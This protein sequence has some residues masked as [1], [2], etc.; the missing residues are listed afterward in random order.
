MTAQRVDRLGRL[1]WAPEGVRLSNVGPPTAVSGAS[2]ASDN[3][4]GAFA[5]WVVT[6]HSPVFSTKLRFQR[7][8][9]D[10]TL[11]TPYGTDISGTDGVAFGDSPGLVPDGAGGIFLAWLVASTPTTGELY[12]Q[13]IDAS[14]KLLWSAPSRVSQSDLSKTRPSY[15]S[16]GAGGIVI[17]WKEPGQTLT[18]ILA[19]RI[20]RDG[21]PLWGSNGLVLAASTIQGTLAVGDDG[22]GGFVVAWPG[23]Q[24][25][26]AQRIDAAGDPSWIDGGITVANATTESAVGVVPDQIG[27]V[28]IGMTRRDLSSVDHFVQHVDAGGAML[29]N[30]VGVRV[31]ESIGPH[32]PLN[33]FGLQMIADGD[34]GTIVS[35]SEV[36][37]RSYDDETD[38]RAQ[39]FDAA[40]RLLWGST[41]AP[42][43]T[44][45]QSQLY[46]VMI[47]DW[48]GGAT[49]A[50][51]QSPSSNGIEADV[52]GQHINRQG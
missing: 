6:A 20:D 27:G 8:L 46:P 31:A 21:E 49:L 13:R 33:R 45:P 7:V 26:R 35:W 24:D 23:L 47:P 51:S 3:A 12:V 1:V 42:V 11:L 22:H 38:C 44:G 39:K 28:Y 5:A 4:G 50:W 14:G 30:S 41:G 10:G 25:L 16:D 48:N 52:Y 43:S 29:W 2:I 17:A 15:A 18:S 19:Q 37:D 32:G 34:G 36:V 40:G 9:A